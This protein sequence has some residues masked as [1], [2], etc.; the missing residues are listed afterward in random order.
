MVTVFVRL[1]VRDFDTWKVA[2]ATLNDLQQ[3]MGIL[4]HRT[5]CEISDSNEVTIVEDWT[6]SDQAKAFAE[7]PKLRSTMMEAGLL[8]P[9]EVWFTEEA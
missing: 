4:S 7:H 9:P 8:E 1:S 6:S 3:E 2:Y 5:F